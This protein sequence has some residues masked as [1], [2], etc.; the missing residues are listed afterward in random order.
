MDQTL[1][2]E[3]EDKSYLVGQLDSSRIS[4]IDDYDGSAS[5]LIDLCLGDGEERLVI[6]KL[7]HIDLTTKKLSD[8]TEI[9]DIN[10][11]FTDNITNHWFIADKDHI[12][13]KFA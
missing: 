6:P 12:S 10:E 13:D 5:D 7:T 2:S 4:E 1:V 9:V 3:L 8:G 11:H